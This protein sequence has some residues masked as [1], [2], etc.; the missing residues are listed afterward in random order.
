MLLI[1]L[2]ISFVAAR[3]CPIIKYCNSDDDR[4]QCNTYLIDFRNFVCEETI[5]SNIFRSYFAVV[6]IV[7]I[8]WSGCCKPSNRRH[9]NYYEKDNFINWNDK[10]N[11]DNNDNNDTYTSVSYGGT[12]RR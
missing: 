1:L 2:F 7:I 9:Y 10:C 11:N 3:R 4:W 8:G 12:E 5:P 6:F